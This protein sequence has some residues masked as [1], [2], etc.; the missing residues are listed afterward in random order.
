VF[1]ISKH[2]TDPSYQQGSNPTGSA[3]GLDSMT[4]IIDRA[5]TR[6]VLYKFLEPTYMQGSNPLGPILV[7]VAGSPTGRIKIHWAQFDSDVNA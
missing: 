3:S 7:G 1:F 4:I 2:L 5:T 6:K